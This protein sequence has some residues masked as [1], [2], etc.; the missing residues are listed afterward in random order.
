MTVKEMHEE[1]M[2][3]RKQ[4]IEKQ[5]HSIGVSFTERELMIFKIAFN[6]GVEEMNLLN[7]KM[8]ICV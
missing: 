7:I 3:R 5:E 6:S 1:L 2:I 4:S 8:R